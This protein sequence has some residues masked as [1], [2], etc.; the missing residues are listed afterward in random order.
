LVQNPIVIAEQP[1]GFGFSS[2]AMKVFPLWNFRPQ[3]RDGKPISAESRIQVTF[4]GQPPVITV[5]SC[6]S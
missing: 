3:E 2:A 4:T 1:K 5:G 6:D